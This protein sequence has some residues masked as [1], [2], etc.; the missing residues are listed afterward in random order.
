MLALRSLKKVMLYAPNHPKLPVLHFRFL[1][2]VSDH[3]NSL[4]ELTKTVISRGLKESSL[5]FLNESVNES[6]NESANES[7]DVSVNESI[8]VS[9]VESMI[10]PILEPN[11]VMALYRNLPCWG[12][13][14]VMEYAKMEL[15]TLGIPKDVVAGSLRSELLSRKMSLGQKRKENTLHSA[16]SKT[17]ID[18]TH[19]KVDLSMCLAVLKDLRWFV[20][21]LE[22]VDDWKLKCKEVYPDCDYF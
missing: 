4:S 17:A 3:Q 21:D 12:V 7:I 16:F 13:L 22:L 19:W 11:Q 20:Q 18:K 1:R 8:D 14:H 9:I 15:K 5:G 2:L 6:V 10:E